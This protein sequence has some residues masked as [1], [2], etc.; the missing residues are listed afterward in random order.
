MKYVLTPLT[1]L[2]WYLTIYYGIYIAVIG[3]SFMFSLRCL[4]FI[5]AY[6]PLVL[7]IFGISTCI[8]SLLQLVTL[9][10]YGISWFSCIVHSIAGLIGA[11]RIILFFSANPP[12]LVIEDKLYI[13]IIGTWEIAPIKTVFVAIP[14]VVIVMTL[15]L[16]IIIIPIHLKL[17]ADI[18][19][20]KN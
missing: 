10:F 7:I 16:S 15:I 3:M 11:V 5:I 4:W 17:L 19:N 12:E 8:P 18:G 20:D 2:L 14:F 6:W 1:M 13:F 9:K